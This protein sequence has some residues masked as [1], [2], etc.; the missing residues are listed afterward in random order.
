MFIIGCDEGILAIAYR[1]RVTG[2]RVEDGKPA[3]TI[4]LPAFVGGNLEQ[5][6]N[7][8]YTTSCRVNPGA[9]LYLDLEGSALT[10]RIR[11][12]DISPK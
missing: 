1:D 9:G 8:S 3:W 4:R 6:T 10:V 11:D 12:G 2:W 7:A 5:P